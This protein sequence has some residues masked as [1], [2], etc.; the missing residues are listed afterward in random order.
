MLLLLLFFGA[1]KTKQNK[2]IF[3]LYLDENKKFVH[4]FICLFIQVS[5]FYFFLFSKNICK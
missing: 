4:Y 1:N 3:T 5:L 2:Q